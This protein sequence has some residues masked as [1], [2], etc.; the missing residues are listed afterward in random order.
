M[1]TDISNISKIISTCYL[2]DKLLS[3]KFIP[4][5]QFIVDNDLL[6]KRY[7]N[8]YC[9]LPKL[10]ELLHSL[11]EEIYNL[12]KLLYGLLDNSIK[13][14]EYSEHFIV[15]IHIHFYK[16]NNCCIYTE[17]K[18]SFDKKGFYIFA[19]SVRES[20]PIS[21]FEE[22]IQYCSSDSIF[23]NSKLNENCIHTVK[24]GIMR[25]KE[26]LLNLREANERIERKNQEITDLKETIQM[27]E[28]HISG[29]Y[30]HVLD[31]HETIRNQAIQLKEQRSEILDL[32]GTIRV[33]E[34]LAEGTYQ[35]T[36]SHA[37]KLSDELKESNL[38]IVA[39]EDKARRY[40]ILCNKY[41]AKFGKKIS[42]QL[43]NN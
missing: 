36:K 13:D 16:N 14:K 7:V 43:K 5:F 2:N 35:F 25:W 17:F 10:L 11:N 20:N 39:V 23:S 19:M 12:F 1:S 42:F 38:K 22:F 32:E 3:P 26:S 33:R 29:Q 30:E 9:R 34:Q 4:L 27:K 18:Y 8:D 15:E 24:N 40:D 31:C 41:Q 6:Y 28:N 21:D 37:E